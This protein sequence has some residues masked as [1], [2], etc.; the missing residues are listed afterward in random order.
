MKIA[1]VSTILHYHWGGADT[2]WT[3]AAEAA[4]TRGDCVF[5]AIS[6]LTAA[7]P[8]VAAMRAA[9]AI[10]LE[11]TNPSGPPRWTTRLAK[12]LHARLG[13][14]DV[15]LAALENF[16]PEL[17]VFSLGGTYDLLLLPKL[18]DWLV[19]SNTCFQVVANWQTEHPWLNARDRESLCGWFHRAGALNFVSNRNLE[20]TRRHLLVPLP[21]A[22]VLNNPL[23]WAPDDRTPWPESPMARLATVSRL[24][25]GKGIA[26]L[27]HA[28]ATAPSL[29][30]W[31][32]EIFG[33]GPEEAYLRE[34]VSCL[35][36]ET[37]VT[38]RGH[39]VALRD[40][41]TYNHL[42]I[43]P[44][45]DDGVPMTIPEAMLCGRPVL[46]TCVGGAE[47]WLIHGE[48]GFLCPAPT[49]PLLADALRAAFREQH[50]WPIMGAAA[51]ASAL[52]RYRADDYLS[53]LSPEPPM[54]LC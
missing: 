2:L 5:L 7:H 45:I 43:S 50:R 10:V 4:L 52:A 9:G 31:H 35:N 27:L 33:Q 36:L 46:A 53:L 21:N 28:L 40:I 47:D 8:R 48:T 44:A 42:L 34:T 14:R 54:S 49:V 18:A 25:H 41:W 29:P 20:N 11:R 17:V 16:R 26:L 22:R 30:R 1:F 39:V 15:V 37:S 24:D 3:T 19:E 13:A 12:R 23:R 38:F 51:A 6:S 32:L